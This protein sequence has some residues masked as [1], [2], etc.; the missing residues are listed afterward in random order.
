M[1]NNTLLLKMEG[2]SKVFGS[3]RVLNQVNFELRKGEVHILCGENGAGKS[4]LMKIL[5]GIHQPTEGQIFVEGKQAQIHST[6]DSEQYGIAIIHQELNL[7]PTI[8]V[9]ENIYLG[10]ERL[11]GKY[12]LDRKAMKQGCEELFKRLNFEIDFNELIGNLTVAQQQLVQIAKALSLNAKILI[13]DEPFSALSDK[14]SN[15]LFGIMEKLKSEG[16]GIIY[17]DHRIENFY[18]IGD[19]VTVLRD[20]SN[21]LFAY[22]VKGF[23]VLVNQRFDCFSRKNIL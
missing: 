10:N 5:S 3:S 1:E 6:K 9:A 7:C 19:R 23:L 20:R 15:T 2:V 17:I 16:T 11:K 14:E 21:I 12:F 8:T 18:R 4:T 22:L 13:M